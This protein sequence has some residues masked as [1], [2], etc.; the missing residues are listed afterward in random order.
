MRVL[1]QKN[2]MGGA[3]RPPPSLYRVKQRNQP[4]LVYTKPLMQENGLNILIRKI[5]YEVPLSSFVG[6]P[7]HAKV[8]T[9]NSSHWTLNEKFFR[10]IK[11]NVQ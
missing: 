5:V 8:F 4:V 10:F 6:N 7:V 11:Q 1:G 3:K 2:Y 9:N